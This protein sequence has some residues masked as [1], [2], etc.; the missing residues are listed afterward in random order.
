MSQ[1]SSN[2]KFQKK[3]T[4]AANYKFHISENNSNDNVNTII[5]V[6]II[7]YKM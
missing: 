4:R 3:V 1:L 7:N 5:I 2:S 6:N